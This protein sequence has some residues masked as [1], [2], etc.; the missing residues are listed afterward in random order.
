M[1]SIMITGG[2]GFIGSNFAHYWLEKYPEDKV[3]VLDALTYAG[4][5]E[6]LADLD[7]ARCEFV[8]GNIA[9]TSLVEYLLKTH[10]I[11]TIVNFAAESHVDRSISDPD[12]F[13]ET[14]IVGTYNLLKA[15]KHVWLDGKESAPHRFHHVSTD[16]VYGTLAPGDKPFAETNKYLPNSPYSASKASSDHLVRAFHRTYGLD[17][18]I[19]NCSNNYGYFHNPEKLIPLTLTNILRG[20]TIPVYGD[21]VGNV[22]GQDI[23]H[24]PRDD[25]KTDEPHHEPAPEGM[26]AFACTFHKS[27]LSD[28]I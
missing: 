14:N 7:P 12:I 5:L 15:A 13:I 25:Q 17:V 11:R 2:A 20:R 10:G 18:T 26:A 4:N 9:D 27:N 23:G 16:E 28:R 19:S 6:N 21:G 24:G 1:A 22:S 8:H 3:V